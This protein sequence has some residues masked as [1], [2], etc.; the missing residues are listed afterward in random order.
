MST[1]GTTVVSGTNPT[2][3]VGDDPLWDVI[4]VGPGSRD[5]SQPGI[6]R[7]AAWQ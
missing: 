1:N 6:W 4:V 7:N 2:D 3:A 5:W